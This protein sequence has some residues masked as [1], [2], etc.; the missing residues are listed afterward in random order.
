MKNII[1]IGMM[2]SGKTSVG[3]L[4]AKRVNFKFV[5]TDHIIEETQGLSISK[6]FEVDGEAKFRKLEENVIERIS[7]LNHMVVSTGG[8]I[9]LNP[10]N[11]MKLKEMG[12]VIYLRGTVET[13]LNHLAGDSDHRPLLKDNHLETI[14]KVRA[15][16]YEYAASRIIDID[17]KTLEEIGDE[18]LKE[19]KSN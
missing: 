7:H 1:L 13:L 16:L 19:F 6:I 2:G 10:L 18:I 11:T 12:D 9:I 17:H 4:L 5:D 15:S 3:T 8:G 14:L